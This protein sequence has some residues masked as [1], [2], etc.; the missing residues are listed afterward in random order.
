M[1]EWNFLR[2]PLQRSSATL[3]FEPEAP[4]P[5]SSQS[6]RVHQ[7]VNQ[8]F[9]FK[10][11]AIHAQGSLYHKPSVLHRSKLYHAQ[12]RS[13]T[14]VAFRDETRANAQDSD[15]DDV[16]GVLPI[17]KYRFHL[18]QKN[19]G[20]SRIYITPHR[21]NSSQ[22][23]LLYIKL[24]DDMQRRQWTRALATL[25]S[26]HLPTL[27]SLS[28]QATIGS[29]FSSKVLMIQSSH[30]DKYYALKVIQKA[31]ILKSVAAFTHVAAER[32]IM[33]KVGPHP[34]VIPLCFAFQTR[35]CLYMATPF[36]AGGDLASYMR[37]KL[38]QPDQP[39]VI[40]HQSKIYSVSPSHLPEWQARLITAEVILG[41]E[42][43]HMHGIVY[44][45]LKL[46]NVFIDGTGHIKIGDL[47]LSKY[48]EG[49]SVGTGRLRT[50]TICGTRNYVA[51]EMLMGT[52]YSFEV[53]L[54]SLG[55]MLYRILV[56]EYPYRAAKAKDLFE[57]IKFDSVAIPPWLSPEATD[58]LKGLLRKNP[59]DRLTINSVKKHPFFRDLNWCG[60][61][62]LRYE[63]SVP[64]IHA[65]VTP[66]DAL[67]NFDLR[68]LEDA[69]V[70]EFTPESNKIKAQRISQYIALDNVLIGFEYVRSTLENMASPLSLIA[71]SG[72]LF[73]KLASI[74]SDPSPPWIGPR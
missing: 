7:D 65:G 52:A 31:P 47:G 11:L 1:P 13:F 67:H 62:N 57:I 72:S 50:K 61:L 16:M 37:G 8:L 2:Y 27:P 29:G 53:D 38:D 21:S 28:V 44:R 60:V 18:T 41:L 45:D 74:D 14:I 9:L 58:L 5:K 40:V 36:C 4:N 42:H 43:L 48:L 55:V 59:N 35:N 26:S 22:D 30:D 19:N 24:Q 33:A 56:G 34:F 23:P 73:S 20:C 63:A 46:E 49:N 15:L 25:T 70:G 10:R 51:P 66:M 17:H 69:T 3:P 68:H 71:T 64:D 6:L 12:L 32:E 39:T 54:W